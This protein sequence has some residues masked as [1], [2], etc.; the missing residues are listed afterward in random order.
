MFILLEFRFVENETDPKIQ[1]KLLEDDS[2]TQKT[3]LSLI[4]EINNYHN[5]QPYIL[6]CLHSLVKDLPG[7]GFGKQVSIS[8][9]IYIYTCNLIYLVIFLKLLFYTICCCH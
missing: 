8:L 6:R 9:Y 5:K 1:I 4:E 7:C 3:I 2:Y